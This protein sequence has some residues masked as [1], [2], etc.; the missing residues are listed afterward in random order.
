MV[1]RVNYESEIEHKDELYK[2]EL[3]GIRTYQI[4]LDK[5]MTDFA[6]VTVPRSRQLQE[7][8]IETVGDLLSA[9]LLQSEKNSTFINF[10]WLADLKSDIRH[11][12]PEQFKVGR[13]KGTRRTVSKD[14]MR[15]YHIEKIED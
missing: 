1:E 15:N 9:L 2:V 13:V 3:K 10:T 4:D 5:K 12:T 14:L 11:M 6:K 7:R 8:R